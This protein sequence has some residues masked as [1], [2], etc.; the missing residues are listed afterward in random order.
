MPD[1][2]RALPIEQRIERL[3]QLYAILR[4]IG[5]ATIAT[6]ALGIII[7]AVV[8]VNLKERA[9]LGVQIAQKTCQGQIDGRKGNRATIVRGDALLGRPGSPGYDYWRSHPQELA[10]QH[11]ET[12]HELRRNY[13]AP[14][15]L[16]DRA[17]RDRVQ[18]SYEAQDA[19]IR[20]D[21]AE[22]KTAP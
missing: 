8:L 12:A 22:G 13:S 2:N 10:T 1:R 4:W 14:P 9:D 15:C 11:A 18:A 17:E 16:T 19:Q 7:L 20:R 21:V 5:A 3:E 6:L